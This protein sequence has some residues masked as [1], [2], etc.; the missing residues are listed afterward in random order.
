MV[1]RDG[2]IKI[3]DYGLAKARADEAEDELRAAGPTQTATGL[4]I[5]TVPY[6]SPEQAAG[7]PADFRSDQFSFGV[8][9]YEMAT[10]AHPFMRATPVQT[11]S[12]VITDEPRRAGELN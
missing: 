2:R 6:M 7:S 3:V 1:T 11:L 8:T 12:A 5:G 10:G 9:L 4:V